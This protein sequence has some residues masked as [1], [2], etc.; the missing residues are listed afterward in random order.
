MPRAA[1]SLASRRQAAAMS[2][3]RSVQQVLM[4]LMLCSGG[5]QRSMSGVSSTW[6]PAHA[7]PS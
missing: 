1:D 2:S 3:A 4:S 7:S 5:W 6:A